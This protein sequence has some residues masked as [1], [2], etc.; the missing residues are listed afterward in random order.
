MIALFTAVALAAAPHPMDEAACTHC[1]DNPHPAVE[2]PCVACHTLEAWAPSTLTVEDHVSTGFPLEGHHAQT[3]C[4]DCHLDLKLSGIPTE[5]AGCHVD[6]HRGKLGQDC[7][8]CHSVQ[9]FTPVADFDHDAKTGFVLQGH[10]AGREC[11]ECHA[12][13]RGAEMA[14]TLEPTCVTCHGAG[15]GELGKPCDSCHTLTT[16]AFADAAKGFD[17]RPTSFRLERRHRALPCAACHT[18]GQKEAPDAACAS[19][20]T[21]VH[22]GQLGTVC[23]DCHRPDRWTVARFDHDQTSWPLRGRHFVT[24]CGSCHTVQNW[25]GLQPQCASCHQPDLLRAPA[26]V[27]AHADPLAT[28]EDCHNNWSWRIQ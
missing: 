24:P 8:E 3:D 14:M 4:V 19:C 11:T 2:Q 10:H 18:V 5:C 9:G 20:H 22:A 6:R 27:D 23:S 12:G 28:C 15:H 16:S 25:L 21:D 26:W 1:H 17:H 13:T 7:T